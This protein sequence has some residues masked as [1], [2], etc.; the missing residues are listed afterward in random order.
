MSD[1]PSPRRADGGPDPTHADPDNPY[2]RDPHL[3]FDPVAAL[4]RAAAA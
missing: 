3:E 2:L 4:S 1:E